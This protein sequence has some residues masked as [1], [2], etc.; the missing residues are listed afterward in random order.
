M[1]RYFAGAALGT[2]TPFCSMT[3]IPV[4]AGLIQAG[5][6]FGPTMAF[7]VSSPL[8]DGI[9]LG[10]LLF[11]VG[12]KLTA[13]YAVIAFLAS[14]AIAAV[15]ARAGLGVDV[16]R[17]APYPQPQSAQPALAARPT[18]AETRGH[19]AGDLEDAGASVWRGAA[20]RIREA[21]AMAWRAF[22]P[23]VP[24]LLLGSAI[25]ALLRG[26]LPVEWILAVAGPGQARAIPLMAAIGLPVYINAEILLPITAALL[27]KGIGPGP[28]MAFVITGLGLSAAEVVLLTGIFRVRVIAA[29]VLSFFAI[30]VAGGSLASLL[31]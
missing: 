6:P 5:V 3:T 12:P 9:V 4:L 28:V 25:G 24:H 30:A 21:W 26:F 18:L 29:L 31:A 14:M 2:V 1:T 17:L 27:D 19:P 22:R 10:V 23:L 13:I 11:L 7:L 16:K 8:L 20:A 15:F